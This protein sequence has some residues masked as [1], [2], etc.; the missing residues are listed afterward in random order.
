MPKL[1][2]KRQTSSNR[3]K[4]ALYKEIGMKESKPSEFLPEMHRE[5]P[6]NRLKAAKSPNPKPL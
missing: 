6:N 1:M 2:K 5:K 4:F 3:W